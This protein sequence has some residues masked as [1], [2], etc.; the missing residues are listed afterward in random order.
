MLVT[1][2]FKTFFYTVQY[3]QPKEAFAAFHCFKKGNS[4]NDTTDEICIV[5]ESDTIIIMTIRNWFKRYKVG[6]FD[7]KDESRSGR[8]AARD[9]EL[10]KAMLAENLQYNVRK[11]VNAINISKTTVIT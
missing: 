7:S 10:I 3:G 11:I 9:T 6:N 5:Y 2:S 1:I 8:P 4:A